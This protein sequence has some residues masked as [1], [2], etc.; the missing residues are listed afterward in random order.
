MIKLIKCDNAK[1]HL[2]TINEFQEKLYDYHV[3]ILKVEIP[4]YGN[5]TTEY[6]FNMSISNSLLDF[7]L[8]E[9]DNNYIGLVV[10]EERDC[11]CYIYQLYVE[12]KN[13]GYGKYVM[14][15][16]KRI[17]K[18]VELSVFK[19]NINAMRFYQRVGFKVIENLGDKFKMKL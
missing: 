7:F 9:K 3:N 11:G 14:N 13:K 1:I 15:I 10:L 18:N 12:D 5:I 2:S 6:Q 4:P 8:V 17:Y 19:D 16:L